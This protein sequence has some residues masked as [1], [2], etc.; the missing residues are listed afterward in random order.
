[1]E[2]YLKYSYLVS[3]YNNDVDNNESTSTLQYLYIQILILHIGFN[4]S[5]CYRKYLW[6]NQ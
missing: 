6:Y 2:R 3:K 4:I 5:I 1:M